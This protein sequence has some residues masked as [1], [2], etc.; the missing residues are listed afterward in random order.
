MRRAEPVEPSV[1]P[2]SA[3]CARA[4]SVS[5]PPPHPAPRPPS[6]GFSR[7]GRT[8]RARFRPRP[9]GTGRRNRFRFNERCPGQYIGRGISS[10]AWFVNCDHAA[11]PSVLFLR[12]VFLV[13]LSVPA[14]ARGFAGTA[15]SLS[16]LVSSF[17]AAANRKL[18]LLGVSS[19]MSVRFPP[20]SVVGLV[21][22]AK[23]CLPCAATLTKQYEI[24]RLERGLEASGHVAHNN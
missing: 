17:V 8:E 11:A 2:R 19:R 23:T 21:N 9:L 13:A 12:Y 4:Q 10:L 15:C 6:R 3:L 1:E 7:V 22:T 16:A 14:S 5:P 20:L 24:S 18:I